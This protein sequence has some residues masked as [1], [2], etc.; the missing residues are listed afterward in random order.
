MDGYRVFTW[1]R[2]AFPD[3]LA[4]L[5]R[6]RKKGFRVVTIIDPEINVSRAIGFLMRLP[7][8]T[9]CARR[10]EE[11]FTLAKCGRG[12]LHFRTSRSKK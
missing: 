4:L 10:R 9:S 6:L 11:L 7:V 8:R 12:E 1:N 2:E 5:S 3:P